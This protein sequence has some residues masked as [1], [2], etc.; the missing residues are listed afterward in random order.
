[1]RRKSV[2][3]NSLFAQQDRRVNGPKPLLGGKVRVDK[4]SEPLQQDEGVR[5]CDRMRCGLVIAQSI[6][7]RLFR[8]RPFVQN[9]S[10]PPDAMVSLFR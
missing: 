5:R 3:P 1:M 9:L 10:N 4:E 2:N 8:F 7:L 6:K